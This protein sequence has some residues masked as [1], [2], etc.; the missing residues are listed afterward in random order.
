MQAEERKPLLD[1]RDKDH[2][3]HES[4]TQ[5]TFETIVENHISSLESTR[6]KKLR[7]GPIC[8]KFL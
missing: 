4:A 7:G 2:G 8:P 3:I 5:R 1:E 6:K